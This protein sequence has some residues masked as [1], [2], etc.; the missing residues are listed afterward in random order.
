MYITSMQYYCQSKDPLDL[1]VTL[2]DNAEI[3]TMKVYD[4]NDI[5]EFKKC[6]ESGSFHIA[7]DSDFYKDMSKYI[8]KIEKIMPQTYG[9]NSPVACSGSIWPHPQNIEYK[10]DSKPEHKPEPKEKLTR[11]VII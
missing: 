10:K 3:I 1:I 8:I 9:Y 7:K 6:H 11:K 4:I 2:E 5:M